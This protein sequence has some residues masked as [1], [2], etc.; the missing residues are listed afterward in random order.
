MLN[1]AV[2]HQ[3]SKIKDNLRIA[4]HGVE[5]LLQKAERSTAGTP[6]QSPFAIVNVLIEFGNVCPSLT[7]H[8]ILTDNCPRPLSTTRM[9]W[10]EL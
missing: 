7:L 1:L 8:T 3:N 9:H 2:G 10:M 5:T 6:F 4:W